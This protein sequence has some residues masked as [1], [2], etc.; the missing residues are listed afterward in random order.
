[1]TES[2]AKGKTSKCQTKRPESVV[3]PNVHKE[4]GKRKSPPFSTFLAIFLGFRQQLAAKV[5]TGNAF[6]ARALCFPFL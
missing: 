5:L 3:M 1:M 2:W 4:Q 6:A